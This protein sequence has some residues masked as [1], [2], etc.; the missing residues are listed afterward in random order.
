MDFHNELL[1]D[2]SP[3]INSSLFFWGQIILSEVGRG[4]GGEQGWSHL[5]ELPRTV[6]AR[7]SIVAQRPFPG[8]RFSVAGHLLLLD[9][10]PLLC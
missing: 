8:P 6:A 10:R 3:L 2:N 9:A 1:H 5:L 4:G 7:P